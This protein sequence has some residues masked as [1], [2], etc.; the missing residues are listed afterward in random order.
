[1]PTPRPKKEE[2]LPTDDEEWGN[3]KEQREGE[4]MVDYLARMRSVYGKARPAGPKEIPA[5]PAS[6]SI[7]AAPKAAAYYE[8]DGG[9]WYWWDGA[10]GMG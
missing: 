8:V 7:E 10:W 6:S 5:E 1:M 4:K 2:K 3:W 9:E